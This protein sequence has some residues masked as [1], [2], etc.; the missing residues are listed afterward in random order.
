MS[1]TP[2]RNDP[3]PLDWSP[4][5]LQLAIEAWRGLTEEQQAVGVIGYGADSAVAVEAAQRLLK[6]AG[7]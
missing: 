1:T 4:L 5:E 3:R 6:A 7:R 2:P